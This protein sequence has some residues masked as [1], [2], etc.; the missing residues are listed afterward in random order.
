MGLFGKKKKEGKNQPAKGQTIQNQTSSPQLPELPKL[1][2]L[3]NSQPS[4]KQ[5]HQ[6]PSIPSS[7][8]G[9]KFS[10]DSIKEAVS[11]RRGEEDD[12]NGITQMIQKPQRKMIRELDEEIEAEELGVPSFPKRTQ[13]FKGRR[14]TE[15]EPIF[16][17]IDNFEEAIKT[18][19]EANSKLDEMEKLLEKIKQ[20]KSEEEQE[21]VSWEKN[22]KKLKREIE[23]IDQDIFSKI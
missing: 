10:Q 9:D 7:S 14:H 11:G 2:D 4:Q 12:V 5:V 8:I 18:F 1:P 20:V 16:V 3:P 21:L 22:V 6:L 15:G 23:K 17:R 13:S 19:D